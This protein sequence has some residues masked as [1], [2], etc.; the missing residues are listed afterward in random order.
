MPKLVDEHDQAED[1]HKRDEIG[2]NAAPQRM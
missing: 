1:E 2:D